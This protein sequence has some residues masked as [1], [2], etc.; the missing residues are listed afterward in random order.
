M[1][2]STAFAANNL[3]LILNNVALADLGNTAGLQPSSVAGS[4]YIALYQSTGPGIG[5]LPTVNE[6]SY[7]GYA[8]VAV[9]RTTGGWTVN[10]AT[11]AYQNAAS[12]AFPVCTGSTNTLTYF[13]ICSLASGGT[14]NDLLLIGALSSS[15]AVSTGITPS[16][17][18]A[19]LTGTAS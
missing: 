10:T 6:A 4:V 8:R 19:A 18:A 12:I 17:A 2:A 13:A 14:V 16:F 15:L 3:L 9:A 11:A 7:T 5:G 1:P